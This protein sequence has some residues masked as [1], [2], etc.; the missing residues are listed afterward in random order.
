MAVTVICVSLG[1]SSCQNEPDTLTPVEQTNDLDWRSS[2]NN[3]LFPA[4][5]HPYGKSYEEWAVLFWQRLMAFDCATIFSENVYGLDQD[6][7]VFFLSGSVGTYTVDVTIPKNKAI[8]TPIV[9]YINDFPCPDTSFHPAPG[10]SLE[11]FLQEGA[12]GFID[13]VENIEVTLDGVTLENLENYR[14]SSSLFEFT[15]NAELPTCFDPC[16]TGTEQS[17]VTDGYYLIF[18][19]MSVGQHTLHLYAEIPAFGMVLDGTFNIT[20]E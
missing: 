16:V 19:K 6:E 3:V 15:G 7:P 1:L 14:L 11:D 17:A 9:N 2:S 20:V 4:N 13:L 18:K 12:A 8:L 5:A 10:Q